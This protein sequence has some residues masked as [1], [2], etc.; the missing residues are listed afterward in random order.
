MPRSK[1]GY[2]EKR[3]QT[4]KTTSK[5]HKWTQKNIMQAWQDVPQQTRKSISVVTKSQNS[6]RDFLNGNQDVQIEFLSHLD[7]HDIINFYSSSRD[8]KRMIDDLI[9]HPGFVVK[10][11]RVLSDKEIDFF[12]K[13]TNT[14]RIIN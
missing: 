13:K 12:R 4:G 7:P 9:Y 8:N 5:T 3:R 2:S 14:I 6:A 10:S 11:N 1:K